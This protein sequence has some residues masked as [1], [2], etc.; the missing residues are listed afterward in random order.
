VTS[1]LAPGRPARWASTSSAIRPA[2]RLTRGSG[3]VPQQSLG[4]TLPGLAS[5]TEPIRRARSRTADHQG[6]RHGSPSSVGRL[7][8]LHPGTLRA[9]F[10][11]STLGVGVGSAG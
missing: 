10:R 7:G 4:G 9:R 11:S 2:S 5:S 6:R 8:V 3:T 1:T